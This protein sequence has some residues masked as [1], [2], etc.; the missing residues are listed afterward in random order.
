MYRTAK[1][2][3]DNFKSFTSIE[4]KIFLLKSGIKWQIILEKSPWLGGLCERLEGIVKNHR[5]SM[6]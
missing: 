4:L 2:I 3:G 1:T 5:E 6:M